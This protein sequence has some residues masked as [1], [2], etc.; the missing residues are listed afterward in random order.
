MYVSTN[1]FCWAAPAP[2]DL[3]LERRVYLLETSLSQ[4][5][6]S[7]VKPQIFPILNLGGPGGAFKDGDQFDDGWGYGL[8]H[9]F[10]I[11][12]EVFSVH[13]PRRYVVMSCVAPFSF[14]RRFESSDAAAY[15]RSSRQYSLGIRICLL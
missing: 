3:I 15:L 5:I 11:T 1:V 13:C 10:V 9:G 2:P 14:V 12:C 8:N 7:Q 6:T 4:E